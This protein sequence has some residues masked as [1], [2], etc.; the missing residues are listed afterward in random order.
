MSPEQVCSQ[1][2]KVDETINKQG[3]GSGG[4]S[5][6]YGTRKTASAAH[7]QTSNSGGEKES[8]FMIAPNQTKGPR[9]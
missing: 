1:I 4:S 3:A 6:V 8:G 2:K 9:R 5:P 7:N